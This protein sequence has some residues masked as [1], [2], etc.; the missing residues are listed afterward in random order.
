MR[1]AGRDCE[2][3]PNATPGVTVAVG[4]MTKADND[5]ELKR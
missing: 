2:I 1:R 3:L 5:N 4:T